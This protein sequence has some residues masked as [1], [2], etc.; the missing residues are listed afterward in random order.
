MSSIKDEIDWEFPGN[1]TTTG[2]TNY[3]WQ[4]VIRKFLMAVNPA[5]Y[6]DVLCLS[7]IRNLFSAHA[8]FHCDQKLH[9]LLV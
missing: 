6:V 1:Q 4:G 3:F 2:Q 7:S 5:E 8:R 9:K